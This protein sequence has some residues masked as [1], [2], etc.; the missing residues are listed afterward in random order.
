M[1]HPAKGTVQRERRDG[2]WAISVKL[3]F[4]AHSVSLEYESIPHV[5]CAFEIHVFARSACVYNFTYIYASV[6]GANFDGVDSSFHT[7]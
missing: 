4:L 6:C 7:L 1:L 5:E 2:G 3:N